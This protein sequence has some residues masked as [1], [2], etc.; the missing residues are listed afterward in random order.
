MKINKLIYT[1]LKILII[2]III[3]SDLL[4]EFGDKIFFK[5]I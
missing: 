4:D 1:I 3:K 2:I 5:N